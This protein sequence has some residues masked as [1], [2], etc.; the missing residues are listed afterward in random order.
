MQAQNILA[1]LM[2]VYFGRIPDDEQNYTLF[3]F[4]AYNAGPGKIQSLRREAEKQKLDPNVCFDNVE[5]VA[6]AQASQEPVRYLRNINKYYLACKP[7]EEADAAKKA[8]PAPLVDRLEHLVLTILYRR[9]R[10]SRH[11]G[12]PTQVLGPWAPASAGA[13]RKR[14]RELSVSFTPLA[15]QRLPQSAPPRLQ[16][17][18]GGPCLAAAGCSCC[19]AAFARAL[20][21]PACA[22]ERRSF[23]LAAAGCKGER[24]RC[25][26]VR[27]ASPAIAAPSSPAYSEPVRH[28]AE[29]RPI[30]VKD[31][32]ADQI[33]RICSRDLGGKHGKPAYASFR[34]RADIQRNVPAGRAGRDACGQHRPAGAGPAV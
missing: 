29:H 34:Q 14:E 26:G 31:P 27:G 22:L 21:F 5:R 8:R 25:D 4:A 6:T 18:G 28:P 15:G 23:K 1:R 24:G 9:A 10:E 33:A 32:K 2:D 13:T 20:N 3:A 11:P 19:Q 12:H 30:A 17:R 7:I 16:L